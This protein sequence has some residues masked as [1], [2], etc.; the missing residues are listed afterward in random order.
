MAKTNALLLSQDCLGRLHPLAFLLRKPKAASL[1]FATLAF[2]VFATL[3][4]LGV[5]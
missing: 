2:G 1:F 5:A 3:A 4:Y